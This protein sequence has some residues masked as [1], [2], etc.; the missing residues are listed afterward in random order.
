[1]YAMGYYSGIRSR[2]SCLMWQTEGV[3]G[4]VLSERQRQM[5][6]DLTSTW[7]L[8]PNNQVLSSQIWRTDQWLP[9]LR[10]WGDGQSVLHTWMLLRYQI[11]KILIII[12]RCNFYVWWLDPCGDYF[13]VY[14][15]SKSL[16]CILQ[17]N[18]S[19]TLQLK[20]K[21]VYSFSIFR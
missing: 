4:T 2:K 11:L 16:R 13:S 19:V 1:M 14:T 20:K 5:P 8:N 3:W 9:E 21:D 17:A 15:N 6:Y 7:N 10:V 18:M 12:Q